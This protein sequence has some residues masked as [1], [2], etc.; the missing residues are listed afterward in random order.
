M[1][2]NESC[3]PLCPSL[4]QQSVFSLSLA[5]SPTHPIYLSL[6][7]VSW[8]G[9]QRVDL[10]TLQS[11]ISTHTRFLHRYRCVPLVR[12][13]RYFQLITVSDT[14]DN[15]L[16]DSWNAGATSVSQIL[17]AVVLISVIFPWFL[18]PVAVICKNKFSLII[19]PYQQLSTAVCYFYFALF[20]R[21]SSTELQVSRNFS[22]L[23]HRLTKS[24]E[25]E[26]VEAF[27]PEWAHTD[28]TYRFSLAVHSLFSF[29]RITIRPRDHPSLRGERPLPDRKWNLCWQWK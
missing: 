22:T 16:S 2:S 6:L 5:L 1:R 23:A 27:L 7:D 3:M 13:W 18:L 12:T 29:L 9:S 14:I 28:T 19:Y 17:G 20:Y 21:A 26:F 8:T 11:H 24:S 15:F 10:W 4:I 25:A